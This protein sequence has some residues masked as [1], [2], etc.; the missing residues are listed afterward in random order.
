[1]GG[2]LVTAVPSMDSG[3]TLVAL[4][5]IVTVTGTDGRR[6]LPLADFFVGPRKTILK[7][8]KSWSR[9]SS[10]KKTSGSRHISSSLVS[11]RARPWR[12]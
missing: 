5:A 2:N 6:Q 11:A 12:S 7:P 8:T 4:D 10:R 1:L 3:P 9:S